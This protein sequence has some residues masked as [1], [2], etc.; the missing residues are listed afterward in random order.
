MDD[1]VYIR[2]STVEQSDSLPV[3]EK[4]CRDFAQTQDLCSAP[5]RPLACELRVV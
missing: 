1:L 5:S 2:V 4:K 3:Q